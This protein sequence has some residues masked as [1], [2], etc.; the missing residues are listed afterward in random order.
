MIVALLIAADL[1]PPAVAPAARRR[2]RTGARAGRR[3]NY[4][5][6]NRPSP[7]PTLNPRDLRLGRPRVP[8]R[9][10][11]AV[12]VDDGRLGT[13]PRRAARRGARAARP[14]RR[15]QDHHGG[16]VRGLHPA[17]RRHHRDPRPRPGRRQRAAARA[18]RRD[19]AG[20]RRLSRGAG[21]RDA[22]SGRRLRRQSAR[23]AVADG[24]ARPDRGGAHH[25]P[26]ALRRPAAAAGAGVRGRRPTRAGVPRRADRGHGRA[27]ANRGVGVDRRAAPRRRHGGAD[28]PPAD[29][30]RGAG[31]PDRDHRPRRR[32][33]HRHT[34][35][36]D[37]QRRREPVAVYARHGCST[38]RC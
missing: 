7:T 26:T 5:G 27:R 15:G 2:C 38:C 11:Q 18:H 1:L 29:R 20:R 14:Q 36:A 28:H 8:A 6:R 12:R 21:R 34:G 23:P 10:Q 37:A 13:R 4:R 17:R 3:S 24:H 19:A 9:G 16:D 32:G 35:R 31:R 33:G 30:G 22:Q 25:L